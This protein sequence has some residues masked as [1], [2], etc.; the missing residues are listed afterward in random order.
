M[1]STQEGGELQAEGIAVLV[2]Q[3]SLGYT[4]DVLQEQAGR[5][6]VRGK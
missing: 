2:P 3:P 6:V 1:G 4:L 5:E